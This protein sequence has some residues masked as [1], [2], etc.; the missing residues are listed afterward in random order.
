[1][2]AGR[3]LFPLSVEL[4]EAAKSKAKAGTKRV[5]PKHLAIFYGQLADLLK[6]GVPLLRS[7]E[8]LERK[9]GVPALQSVLEDVR[10]R[11]R[12]G[13]PARRR[14][15]PAPQSVQRAGRQHGYG[16]G[17]RAASSKTC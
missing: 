4:N 11:G 14:P 12:G 6:S 10:G 3:G 1:M 7:I 8:L 5:S 13:E 2:L 16:P 15:P 9:S 17:R